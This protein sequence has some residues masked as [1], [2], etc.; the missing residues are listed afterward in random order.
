[1]DIKNL[2]PVNHSSLNTPLVDD[3]TERPYHLKCI[4]VCKH[5]TFEDEQSKG[6]SNGE[7]T[8]VYLLPDQSSQ[9]E[10]FMAAW[11]PQHAN[12]HFELA[13]LLGRP[14]NAP[15]R[16]SVHRATQHMAEPHMMVMSQ[17]AE[18]S[19]I[20]FFNANLEAAKQDR[21][22]LRI[23]VTTLPASQEGILG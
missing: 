11:V 7:T 9:M 13:V 21:L 14:F 23:D 1:M 18:A 2:G 3:P 20:S 8:N 5:V 19:L 6:K 4:V 15:A 12:E 10:L 17:E 22:R 16:C